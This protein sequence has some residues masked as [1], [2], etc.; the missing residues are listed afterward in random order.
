MVDPMEMTPRQYARLARTCAREGK[1]TFLLSDGE[2]DTGYVDWRGTYWTKNYLSALAA[3]FTS[4]LINGPRDK[5]SRRAV[6][7]SVR[8]WRLNRGVIRLP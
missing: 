5:A 8:N 2:N 1:F 4:N 6:I 3:L 7:R